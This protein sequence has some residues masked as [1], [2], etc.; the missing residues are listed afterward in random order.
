MDAERR[1]YSIGEMCDA[2]G[3]TARALR[4]YEDEKL[5]APERRG[6]TR[7][8]TDRDRGRLNWIL[9]GKSVGFSLNDI[10]ELLD[11]YDVGDQ[12]HTQMVATRDRC[13]DRI[14]A[15]HRQKHDID[16][17]IAELEEFCTFLDDRLD[18]KD[19][20]D[21]DIRRTGS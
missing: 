17:T 3:V 6:T 21:A 16:T 10:R 19:S 11:L 14:D 12:Q 5:I 13:R 2:F 15:L 9:R 8:Y 20:T 7:L 18:Q 1:Y 4:F